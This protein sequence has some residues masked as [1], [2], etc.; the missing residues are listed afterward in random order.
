MAIVENGEYERAK[1]L[2]VESLTIRVATG[3]NWGID[4][5]LEGLAGVA[6]AEGQPLRSARLFGAADRIRKTMGAPLPP[7]ERPTYERHQAIARA[8]I[9]EAAFEAAWAEGREMTMEQAIEYA[10]DGA[11][12]NYEL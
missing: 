8:Q 2:L 4:E 9:D 6:G 3:V 12:G 5:C 10:R 7:A 11:R 1:S